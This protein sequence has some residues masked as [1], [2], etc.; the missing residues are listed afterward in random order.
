MRADPNPVRLTVGDVL[1]FH[2][3]P[4]LA[5]GNGHIGGHVRIQEQPG[6]HTR[7]NE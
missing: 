6:L 3:G 4:Q 5:Q 1:Y 2:V 7:R